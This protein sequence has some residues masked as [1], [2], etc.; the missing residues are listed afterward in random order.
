M[1]RK[2]E[3]KR[4]RYLGG[5]WYKW[6]IEFAW[7][8]TFRY[9]VH[10][11]EGSCC[12][13]YIYIYIY[14]F[15]H[16]PQHLVSTKMERAQIRGVC[17]WNLFQ[18]WAVSKWRPRW[19]TAHASTWSEAKGPKPA[20]QSK[21][22]TLGTWKEQRTRCVS[23]CCP[24]R[25]SSTRPPPCE[26]VKKKKEERRRT[27]FVKWSFALPARNLVYLGVENTGIHER[28]MPIM[29]SKISAPT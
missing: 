17:Y 13:H 29:P 24:R 6:E 12:N 7:I 14:W 15:H 19:S 18:H 21:Y 11:N 27:E 16:N 10:I 25:P 9:S 23:C 22:K 26:V 3:R 5:V 28:H 8:P 2:W 20:I 4:Q 1:N